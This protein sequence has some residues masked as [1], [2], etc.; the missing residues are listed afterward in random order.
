[1]TL[2][3]SLTSGLGLQLARL[4]PETLLA[5]LFSVIMLWVALRMYKQSQP[6]AFDPTQTAIPAAKPCTLNP[7]TGK[8]RWTR[9]CTATLAGIGALT[10]L[11]AGMLGVGGGFIVVP[12]FKR[13]TNLDMHSIV[14]TSL[15]VIALIASVTAAHSIWQGSKIPTLGWYFAVA[16]IAGMVLGRILMPHLPASTLQKGFA[17]VTMLVAIVL[18]TRTWIAV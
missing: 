12:A 16:T 2:T 4:I 10:G 9:P 15:M 3:G 18:M 5:S 6:Q 11:S 8:L 14:A 1:M 17:M 13:Y 7:A